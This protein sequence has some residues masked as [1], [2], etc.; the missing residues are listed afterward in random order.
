MPFLKY[1]CKD[2]NAVFDQLVAAAQMDAVRCESCGGEVE[3]AYEGVCLFGNPASSAGRDSG[4]GGNC[5]GC[6]GCGGC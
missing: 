6:S 1:R 4:C 2:C 3:R 5:S